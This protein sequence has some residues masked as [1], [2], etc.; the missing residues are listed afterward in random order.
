MRSAFALFIFDVLG[1]SEILSSGAALVFIPPSYE[2]L[3]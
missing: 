3:S 2:K 1:R